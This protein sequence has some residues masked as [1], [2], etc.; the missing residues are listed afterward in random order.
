MAIG[1]IEAR[2]EFTKTLLTVWQDI[3]APKDFLKS[4]FEVKT[5]TAKEVSIETMRSNEK[6]ASDVLRGQ[7]GNRNTVSRFTEKLFI[8]KFLNEYVGVTEI[9]GYDVLFGQDVDGSITV[10]QADRIMGDVLNEV[11]KCRMKIERTYEKDRAAV[12]TSGIVSYDSGDSVDFKRKAAS[13]NSSNTDYWTTGS[14]DPHVH[15]KG[16]ADFL[17]KTGK[18]QD[19]TFIVIMG[20]SSVNAFLNNPFIVN[21]NIKDN[22]RI[23]LESPQ[24]TAMGGVPIGTIASGAYNFELWSY[25]NFYDVSGTSTPYLDVKNIIVLPKTSG[26]FIMSYAGVPTIVNTGNASMP[27]A[28]TSVA[29]EYHVNNYVDTFKKKH[30]FEV[31]SAGLPIPVSVDRI[32]TMKVVNA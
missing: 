32:Y 19:G 1:I 14:V 22:M 26:K 13:I 3:V 2:G 30:V 24:M 10:G 8:P 17:R 7:N 16:A 28:I 21:S 11:A 18:A 20:D 4:F 5:T 31:M 15:L 23:M 27:S 12:L 9:D 6:I 25:P 29:G